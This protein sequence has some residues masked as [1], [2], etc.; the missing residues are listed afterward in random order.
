MKVLSLFV[1]PG[2]LALAISAA[3]ADPSPNPEM[4]RGS[5]DAKRRRG[6]DATASDV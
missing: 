3:K 6:A 2:V 5:D 1:V 4:E